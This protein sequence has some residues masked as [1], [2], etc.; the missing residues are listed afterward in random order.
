[1]M[2]LYAR[3]DHDAICLGIATHHEDVS[4]DIDER[5]FAVKRLGA[6]VVLPHSQ[7]HCLRSGSPGL[8]VDPLH[9][10]LRQAEAVPFL[11]K[12]KAPQFDR[13]LPGHTLRRRP[14][15]K[16]RIT[17]QPIGHVNE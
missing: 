1:M 14:L 15:P 5:T 9:Q 2:P 10:H 3:P 8:L 4:T 13:C 11:E 6:F 16:L 12:V 7:P 17:H